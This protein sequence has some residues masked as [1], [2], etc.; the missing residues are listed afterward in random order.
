VT[1]IHGKVTSLEPC[2]PAEEKLATYTLQMCHVKD[3]A[4]DLA[5]TGMS[6]GEVWEGL[7][8]AIE[9][10]PESNKKCSKACEGGCTVDMQGILAEAVRESRE[11]IVGLCLRCVREG[12]EVGEEGEDCGHDVEG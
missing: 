12:V 2:P 1:A 11:G 7:E 4:Y 5:A 8:T 6:M 10:M 3:G 9:N